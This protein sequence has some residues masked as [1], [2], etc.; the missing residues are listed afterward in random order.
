MARALQGLAAVW[1]PGGGY[2]EEAW[3][4]IDAEWSNTS[5]TFRQRV[6]NLRDGTGR[7]SAGRVG[8][9]PMASGPG[10]WPRLDWSMDAALLLAAL[11][12]YANLRRA[13]RAPLTPVR[14][15][16]PEALTRPQPA[17]AP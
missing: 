2:H 8:V 17:A 5:R 3:K 13:Y 12:V 6:D 4:A 9:D 1:L 11:A 14:A 15:D 16:L 7:T 10:G